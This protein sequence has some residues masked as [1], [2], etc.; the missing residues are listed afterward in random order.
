MRTT[1]EDIGVF[2]ELDMVEVLGELERGC[3]L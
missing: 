3:S 2:A 1:M